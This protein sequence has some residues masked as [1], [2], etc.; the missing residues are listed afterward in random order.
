MFIKYDEYDL[1][2]LFLKEP[3]SITDDLDAGELI[4]TYKDSQSFKVILAMDVYRK[5][6][7]LSVT[8]NDSIVFT[9]EFNN[10]TSINKI[11]DFMLINV[12]NEERLKVKFT[13]QV[14]VE[15]L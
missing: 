1:L 9:G 8:Y 5:I 4:Y 11:D 13:N 6:C 3:V 7:S 14:G 10:V 15:L 2:E 12:N